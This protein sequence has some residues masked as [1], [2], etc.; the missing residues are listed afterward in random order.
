MQVKVNFPQKIALRQGIARWGDV[1][2]ELQPVL[3]ALTEEE[4]TQLRVDSGSLRV[5]HDN[6]AFSP[7]FYQVS[8]EDVTVEGVVRAIREVLAANETKHQ[9]RVAEWR[10]VLATPEEYLHPDG[11]R[12]YGWEPEQVDT[13]CAKFGLDAAEYQN[14]LDLAAERLRGVYK[15]SWRLYF[16]DWFPG[17]M[18]A[19]DQPYHRHQGYWGSDRLPI[20]RAREIAEELGFE[21]VLERIQVYEDAIAAEDAAKRA[22][23][24]QS[25]LAW[26][27]WASERGSED[28]QQA[29]E[30]EYPLGEAVAREVEAH[31]FPAPDSE[32]I[33]VRT[34]VDRQEERRVPNQRARDLQAYLID[35]VASVDGPAG[36]ELIVGRIHA[37]GY[38]VKCDCVDADGGMYAKCDD[39]DEDYEIMAMRTAVPV[40][41]KSP[42]RQS[43]RWYVLEE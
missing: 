8:V 21:D 4:R 23:I 13:K 41:L 3:D 42:H 1:S 26:I 7:N 15:Q 24:E 18:Q 35:Q 40:Y 20:D 5:A 14:A 22:R 31:M 25:R 27:D 43:K 33:L 38:H 29:I 2:V 16:G 6:H 10:T 28:L 9:Q 11:R 37:V 34:A 36:V 17:V 32:A 30:D 19:G 12:R 39:C